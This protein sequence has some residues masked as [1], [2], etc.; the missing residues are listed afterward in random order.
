MKFNYKQSRN[1]LCFKRTRCVPL[2]LT[3]FLFQPGCRKLANVEAPF[4]S[5]NAGNVYTDDATA[6][7]VF[8]GLYTLLSNGSSFTGN[9]GISMLCGLSA[10][11]LTLYNQVSDVKLIA[12]HQ[13]K[14]TGNATSST[15][16]EFWAPLYNHIFTCNSAVEGLSASTSLSASVKQQLL[17]EAKFMRAFFYFYLV[18]L[19]GDVPLV[20]TTDYKINALLARAP[21]ADVYQQIIADLNDAKNLL[22]ESYMDGTLQSYPDITSSERVRPTKWAAIALLS[23]TYLYNGDYTNAEAEATTLI[24]NTGYFSLESLSNVFLKNSV[25]AIWQLQ[26]VKNGRNTEEAQVF[27]LTSTG[28]TNSTSRPVYLNS[29]LLNAFETDDQ[30]KVGWVDSVVAEGSGIKYFYASKYKNITSSVTEYLMLLRLG[31][32]FLIRA[33][34]RAKLGNIDGAQS[35]INAIRTRAGLANTT[36]TDQ[37]SLLAAVLHEKQV[38][39]FTEFG[40]RWFDLKRTQTVDTVMGVVTPI[41]ANGESWQSY[42]QL[43]PL[44]FTDIQKDPHLVQNFGY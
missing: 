3:L 23:R 43:Y 44:P 26:P 38:E 9:G 16:S 6:I 33:E 1:C 32:Q 42:Q 22:S 2:I 39:L 36:A 30:R 13:N 5:T 19:Y 17:G 31:E 15:G 12:F 21:K 35:D 11:E 41:K 27:I 24:T 14:L 25:E 7:S 8:T 37:A 20:L 34:A 4:T 40:N 28:P 10:D 18:N 29:Q